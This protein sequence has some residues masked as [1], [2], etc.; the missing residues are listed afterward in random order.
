MWE[1]LQCSAYTRE[2]R[3]QRFQGSL[4]GS[5]AREAGEADGPW[6]SLPRTFSVTAPSLGTAIES[7]SL[8]SQATTWDRNRPRMCDIHHCL[9]CSSSVCQLAVVTVRSKAAL[10]TAATRGSSAASALFPCCVSS[11]R[12]F[13]TGLVSQRSIQVQRCWG[14]AAPGSCPQEAV[15]LQSLGF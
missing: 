10:D 1:G 13:Q 7:A 14:P 6:D 8:Q 9:I 11:W 4:R 2:S 5:P 12:P 15:C 3:A